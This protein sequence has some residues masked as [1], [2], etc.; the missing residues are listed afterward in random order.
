MPD[1]LVLYVTEDGRSR[2]ELRAI[3][4]TVW[5]SLN[6]IADDMRDDHMR[7]GGKDSA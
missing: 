4:G 6:R 3:D 1:S 2:V 7:K 5:L